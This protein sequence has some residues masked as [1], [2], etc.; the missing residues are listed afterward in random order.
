MA[1]NSHA[2]WST[3][4]LKCHSPK[5]ICDI[6]PPAYLRLLATVWNPV[7][8]SL[9]ELGIWL[10][11]SPCNL[12]RNRAFEYG[13]SSWQPWI[14]N[15]TSEKL[16]RSQR[17]AGRAITTQPRTFP[18]EAIHA[19]ANVPSKKTQA[20]HEKITGDNTTKT[21][22]YNGDLAGTKTHLVT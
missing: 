18:V 13:A 15:S 10:S 14:S 16:D 22:T 12:H 17:Y 20:I 7:K 19:E 5:K 3:C 11:N 6:W 8:A 1:T 4:P 9:Y 21:A 2:K